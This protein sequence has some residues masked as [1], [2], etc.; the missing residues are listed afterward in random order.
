MG[1]FAWCFAFYYVF[2]FASWSIKPK[3]TIVWS[4]RESYHKYGFLASSEELLAKS[5]NVVSKPY[6]YN[7][8]ALS[9]YASQSAETTNEKKPDIIYILNETFF[10]LKN[11]ISDL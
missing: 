2:F 5:F 7:D 6:G 10:D 1:I 11:V 8:P 3:L 9:D 4:W